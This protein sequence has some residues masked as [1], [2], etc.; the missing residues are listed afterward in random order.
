MPERYFEK[1]PLVSYSNTIVR[2][3]TARTVVL[4]SIYNNADLYYPYDIAQYERP[5]NLADRYYKDEYKEWIIRLTNKM[6]DPYYDWYLDQET[7][8][9][10]IAKKYGS[11]GK[12]QTKIKYYQNNWYSNSNP[13]SATAFSALPADAARFWEPVL[14][15][16]QNVSEPIEY[17]RVQQDWTLATNRVV[18]YSTANSAGFT[19]DEVVDVTINGSQDGRGQV[20]FANTTTLTIQHTVGT[21]TGTVAGT[22][23]LSGRESNTTTSFTAI[24]TMA[25]NIPTDES[26]Y[27]SAVTYYDYEENVNEKNKSIIILDSS[28]SSIISKQ[29]KDLLS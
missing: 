24:T 25:N 20:V 7:F 23:S 22:C 4:N 28:Y 3:I 29:L 12:A 14:V 9:A 10:F 2:D 16:G 6:I 18:Q 21:V 15:N 5:D 8:N 13:I 27:W 17:R 26:S 19:V 1:F 11:I